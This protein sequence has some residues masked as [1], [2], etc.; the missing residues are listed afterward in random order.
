MI[1]PKITIRNVDNGRR[2]HKCSKCGMV[3]F[4]YLMLLTRF[5]TRYGNNCWVC[6]DNPDCQQFN[7]IY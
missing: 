7:S 1:T 5:I 3:R 4:E 2:R 6:V